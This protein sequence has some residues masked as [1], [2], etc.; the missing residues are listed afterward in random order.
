VTRVGIRELRQQLSRY[1]RA[2]QHGEE[3]VI[4][5]RD[6]AVGRLVANEERPR[7]KLRSHRLLRQRIRAAGSPLSEL[8]SRVRDE[9]RS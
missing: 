1:I 8:T 3:I 2:A 4:T 6:R 7:R 5:D 9:E